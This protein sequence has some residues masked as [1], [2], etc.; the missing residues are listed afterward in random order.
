MEIVKYLSEYRNFIVEFENILK[1]KYQIEDD[2]YLHLDIIK[3]SDFIDNFQ[4]NFHGAGCKITFNKIIC[5]YDF[6]LDDNSKYQFSLWKFK[7]FVESLHEKKLDDAELKCSL[8]NL[9]SENF[10]RKLIIEGKVFDIYLI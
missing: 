3:K 9:V 7:T 6:L 1:N 2:I 4:Y 10:L 8:E 5:E